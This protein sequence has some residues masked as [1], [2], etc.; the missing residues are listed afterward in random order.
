EIRVVLM[1]KTGCGKSAT[2]NTILNSKVFQSKAGSLSTCQDCKKVTGVLLGKQVSVIDS[3]G[4]FDTSDEDKKIKEEIGRSVSLSSPGPHVFLLVLTVG[5]YTK[6]DMAT[7]EEIIKLFSE[8]AAK[9]TIVLFTRLDDLEEEGK[10]LGDFLQRDKGFRELVK[11]FGNRYHGFNNR[12]PGDR[13]QVEKLMS[14]IEDMM[15][16]NGRHFYTN[17]MYEAARQAILHRM[18][19]ILEERR[20]EIQKQERL[21]RSESANPEEANRKIEE[22][23]VREVKR[24]KEQAEQDNAFIKTVARYSGVGG[25][26]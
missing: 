22:L 25:G 13:R 24:A 18:E 9:H 2:G 21:L 15:D 7:V 17:E 20:D 14:K 8:S 10:T 16:K 5:R 12:A 11:R 26:V 1:G 4:V 19:E 6:E 23:W 3:P